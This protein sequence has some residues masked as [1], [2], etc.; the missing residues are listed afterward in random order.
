MT[1]PFPAAKAEEK[2]LIKLHQGQIVPDYATIEVAS[3]DG[4]TASA[5]KRRTTDVTYLDFWKAFDV[6]PHNI[7]VSKLER[8]RFDKWTMSC[9]S[10]WLHGHSQYVDV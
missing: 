2:L 9:I 7:L 1:S 8:Y 3:Y 6:V 5:D 4:V 10:N